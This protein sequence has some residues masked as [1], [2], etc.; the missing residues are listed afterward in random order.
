MKMKRSGVQSV[1]LVHPEGVWRGWGQVAGSVQDARVLPLQNW[2]SVLSW[3]PGLFTG[4]SLLVLV[5]GNCNHKRSRAPSGPRA[6]PSNSSS[7][8]P[9]SPTPPAL[10]RSST[11]L[12]SIQ[13][14]RACLPSRSWTKTLHLIYH[15]TPHCTSFPWILTALLICPHHLS[16]RKE[17]LPLD[18]SLFSALLSRSV[19]LN[20]SYKNLLSKG[21]GSTHPV[22]FC[23]NSELLERWWS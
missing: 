17:E 21:L 16:G 12:L 9:S 3:K 4:L 7:T 10:L 2:H 13:N 5:K 1:F 23:F 19:S 11:G 15:Y 6:R 18:S 8:V 22:F 20:D 14:T